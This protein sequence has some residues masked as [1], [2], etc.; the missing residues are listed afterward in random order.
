MIML[1]AVEILPQKC[2]FTELV[3]ASN[4]VFVKINL[5]MNFHSIK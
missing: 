2:F 1:V 3:Q 5:F 4:I